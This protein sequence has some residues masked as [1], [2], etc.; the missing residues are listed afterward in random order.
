MYIVL[1]ASNKFAISQASSD[2]EIIEEVRFPPVVVHSDVSGLLMLDNGDTLVHSSDANTNL[3][4]PPLPVVHTISS[5]TR[6]AEEPSDE[7]ADPWSHGH[8]PHTSGTD[9]LVISKKAKS[10][11]HTRQTSHKRTFGSNLIGIS[12]PKDLSEMFGY[13]PINAVKKINKGKKH[14]RKNRK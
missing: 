14:R 13:P 1:V 5:S 11:F 10:S 12:A 6:D 4:Q 3:G 2:E 9:A 7:T 8:D